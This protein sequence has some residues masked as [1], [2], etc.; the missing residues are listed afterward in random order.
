[1]AANAGV[2]IVDTAFNSMSGLTSQ[3]ALNSVAAALENT[4]RETGLDMEKIQEISDYWRSVRPVYNKFESDLKSGTAEIY[5]Y[6]IPGGQYSNL[7]PQVESFG[8]GHK[9]KEVK[10]MYKKVNIMLG[11]IIKVTPSSKVVGDL[12]IFM[13]QNNYTPENIYDKAKGQD[14][15]DSVVSYFRGMMGQPQGGFPEK[16]QKLVLKD[17][18]P[19]TVRPGEL[20]EPL[21]FNEIRNKIEEKHKINAGIKDILSYALYPKVYDEYLT[22]V[23]KEGDFTLMGS[24]VY[25]HGLEEGETCE[26]KIAEGK[27]LVVKLVEVRKLDEEGYRDVAFEINGNRRVV[28]IKDKSIKGS[29]IKEEK[30]K[31]DPENQKEIGA[32]IPGKIIKILVKEDQE[33]EVNQPVAIIEAMKM[34]T[35]II[36]PVKG[37]IKEINIKEGQQVE[38]QELIAVIE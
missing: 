22:Y 38:S 11:D 33:V 5:K 9:F 35:K 20:L 31:A 7:K 1:M 14:F 36:A 28:R 25:F 17:E 26:V 4:E 16:L 32:N 21:D 24:D 27:I 29:I 30:R 6:E 34:E 3:P 13:V 15:P 10:E 18:K 19:I 2:D 37:K 12:A 8:L 23:E